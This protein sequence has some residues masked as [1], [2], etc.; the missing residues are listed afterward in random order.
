MEE[1]ELLEWYRMTPRERFAES[2]NLWEVFFMMGGTCDPEPDTQSPFYPMEIRAE[3]APHGRTGLH[4]LRRS[5][6]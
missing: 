2:Q 4:P 1:G 6:I 5:G 3:R